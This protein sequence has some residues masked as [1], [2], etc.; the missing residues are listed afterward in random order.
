[1][2]STRRAKKVR[3]RRDGNRPSHI[4]LS[5]WRPSR[6]GAEARFSRRAGAASGPALMIAFSE[7][8]PLAGVTES[9]GPTSTVAQ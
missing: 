2:P 6:E 9:L 3:N 5:R 1:M 8:L 4:A 7:R